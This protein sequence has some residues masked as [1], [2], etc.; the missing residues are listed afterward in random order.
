LKN[1]AD[2]EWIDKDVFR[3][4]V[5]GVL[6]DEQIGIYDYLFCESQLYKSDLL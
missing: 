4:Q 5:V 1:A 6:N 2:R 3:E